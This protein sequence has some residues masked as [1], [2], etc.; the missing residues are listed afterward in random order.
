M[1]GCPVQ[2]KTVTNRKDI[3]R[4]WARLGSFSLHG[5][6]CFLWLRLRGKSILVTGSC[7]G[8]GRCCRAI[9]LEGSEGWLRSEK[10]FQRVVK[11]Y[12]EYK[13]FAISGRDSQGYLLFRCTWSMADGS[14][15]DYEQRLPLCRNY[16]ESSLIFAG[17]RL[18]PG[19]GYRF[20]EVVPFA[21]ILRRE[22]QRK[23]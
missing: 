3:C 7:H 18:L 15:S 4:F 23:K 9:C 1:D 19:C 11:K 5:L 22:L 17:G 21:R 13:R 8:C 2:W 16:P 14:C 10:S 20:A 12:P 6:C